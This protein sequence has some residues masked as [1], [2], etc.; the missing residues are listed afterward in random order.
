MTLCH[1]STNILMFGLGYYCASAIYLASVPAANFESGTGTLYFTGLTNGQPTWSGVET[2]AVL[3]VTD[4]PTN[5][6]IGNVSVNFS[7]AAG[8]WLMTYDGGRQKPNLKSTTGVYFAFAPAA[9]G[10]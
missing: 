1:F 9:W 2:N 5:P 4:K 6:T 7:P 8:L 10:S 3:L